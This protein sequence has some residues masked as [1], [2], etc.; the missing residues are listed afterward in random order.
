MRERAPP[1]SAAA[2]AGAGGGA[3]R[4][5]VGSASRGPGSRRRASGTRAG[6]G[7]R[8]G[9]GA[10]VGEQ[11]ADVAPAVGLQRRAALH[12]RY[13][14]GERPAQARCGAWSAW[15][16]RG[17]GTGGGVAGLRAVRPGTRSWAGEGKSPEQLQPVGLSGLRPLLPR[18][19]VRLLPPA[20]F[21]QRCRKIP[22]SIPEQG[23]RV[24]ASAAGQPRAAAP[25]PGGQ[26]MRCPSPEECRLSELQAVGSSVNQEYLRPPEAF[27]DFNKVLNKEKNVMN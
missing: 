9:A 27:L 10:G 18:S 23:S 2:P 1:H 15:L 3:Q 21:L 14:D 26:V 12:Y 4:G 8:S 11:Q 24:P 20:L 6:V 16:R 5:H 19:R 17:R 13:G 25:S 22:A 7:A